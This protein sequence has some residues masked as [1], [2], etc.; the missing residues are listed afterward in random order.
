M[1]KKENG[2]SGDEAV[3]H[4]DLFC[5]RT[6]PKGLDAAGIAVEYLLGRHRCS[7]GVVSANLFGGL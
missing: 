7:D 4:H 2:E 3:L 6:H 5:T 1:L